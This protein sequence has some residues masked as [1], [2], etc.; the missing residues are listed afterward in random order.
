MK[1]LTIEPIIEDLLKN[2]DKPSRAAGGSERALYLL[3]KLSAPYLWLDPENLERFHKDFR[4]I[5]V[6][7]SPEIDMAIWHLLHSSELFWKLA[8]YSKA[9]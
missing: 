5:D 9:D 2:L 3:L 4:Q 1:T 6:T 8:P 7:P